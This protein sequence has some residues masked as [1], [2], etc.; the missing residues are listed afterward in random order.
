MT[1]PPIRATFGLSMVHHVYWVKRVF[2]A[3]FSRRRLPAH[4]APVSVR[5]PTTLSWGTARIDLICTVRPCMA[6]LPIS[7][8]PYACVWRTS[9]Y[10]TRASRRLRKSRGNGGRDP[11]CSCHTRIWL[12]H[13]TFYSPSFERVT[14]H[15]KR[16]FKMLLTSRVMSIN[17][18]AVCGTRL[19]NSL[20][21]AILGWLGSAMMTSNQ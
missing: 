18:Y 15:L 7:Q 11:R 2:M 21:R 16:I 19:F 14:N 10:H 3:V 17:P 9:I 13:G 20:S 5:S 12:H 4:S 6:A 1:N 8:L